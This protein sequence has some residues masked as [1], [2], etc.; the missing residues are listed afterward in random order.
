MQAREQCEAIVYHRDTYRYTGQ[1][2]SG[3]S[4]YYDEERCKRKA[5]GMGLC[6]QHLAMSDAGRLGKKVIRFGLA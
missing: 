4:M 1:G 3:F 6:S 5:Q 2:P